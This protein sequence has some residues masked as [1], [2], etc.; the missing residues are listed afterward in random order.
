MTSDPGRD[1][2]PAANLFDA[3]AFGA[4]RSTARALGSLLTGAA[5]RARYGEPP[6]RGPVVPASVIV[7]VQPDASARRVAAGRRDPA[8]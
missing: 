8:A 6:T 2:R 4:L 7:C 5:T 1:D 3:G